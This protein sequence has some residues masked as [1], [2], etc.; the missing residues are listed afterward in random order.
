MRKRIFF[1][2]IAAAAERRAERNAS[3]NQIIA[4]PPSG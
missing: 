3:P 2:M 4:S 1:C